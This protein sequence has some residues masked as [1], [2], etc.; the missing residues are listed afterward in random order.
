MSEAPSLGE[1]AQ[2]N[3][4]GLALLKLFDNYR[5]TIIARA[6]L[7]NDKTVHAQPIELRVE[8]NMKDLRFVL[9]HSG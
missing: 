7:D 2:T 4:K 6:E 3:A 8:K 1:G 5:Y 9:D